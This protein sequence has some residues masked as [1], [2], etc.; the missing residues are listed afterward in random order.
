MTPVIGPEPAVAI[1]RSGAVGEIRIGDGGRRNA[2]PAAAWA[3][4]ARQIRELG[5]CRSL[6]VLVIRGQG[7]TFCAGSDMTDW[8]A[9]DPGRV[10]ESFA[11]MEAAFTA[12]E[13]CPVPVIAEVRGVAAGAG[14]QLALACD[15]RLMADTARI[16]MPIAR[17]GILA[18]PVFAARLVALAGPGTA[19]ELLYTGRLVEARTAVA[20]GLADHCVPDDRLAEHVGRLAAGIADHPPAAIQA[21]KRAVAAA[22]A[23]QRTATAAPQRPVVARPHFDRAIA[24][25]LG[26]PSAAPPDPL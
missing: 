16:G 23:P 26:R 5:A 8:V 19:R 1:T 17:L 18:S 11:H 12:I 3:S 9:A 25:F 15:L 13:D 20:L 10:E 4:L 21:A 14:C 2:L 7:D 22:L 6:R 24:A